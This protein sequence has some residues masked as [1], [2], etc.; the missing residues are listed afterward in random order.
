MRNDLKDGIVLFFGSSVWQVPP[1]K[2]NPKVKPMMMCDINGKLRKIKK[3]NIV[4]ESMLK[5]K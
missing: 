2:L 1:E 3:L 5:T 4:T